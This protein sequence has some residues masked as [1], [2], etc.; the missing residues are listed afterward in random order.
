MEAFG[1]FLEKTE[2]DFSNLEDSLTL[3]TGS[4]GSGKTT[5]FDAICCALYGETSGNRRSFREMRSEMAESRETRVELE[6]ELRGEKYTVARGPTYDRKK[7][8]GEGETSVAGFAYLELPDGKYEE[9]S[10]AVTNRIVELLG[11]ELK[12]FRQIVMIAQNQFM[13]IIL[14]TNKVQEETFNRIFDADLF[15]KFSNKIREESKELEK[16]YNLKFAELRSVLEK[17]DEEIS[18]D[19]FKETLNGLDEEIKIKVKECKTYR[20]DYNV[21]KKALLE[22]QKRIEREKNLLEDFEDRSNKKKDLEEF[23]KSKEEIDE[24]KSVKEEAECARDMVRDKYNTLIKTR[25]EFSDVKEKL[26][27]KREEY[28]VVKQNRTDA[29]NKLDEY[30]EKE[31]QKLNLEAE[32]AE[33]KIKEYR[34]I[35]ERREERDNKERAYLESKRKVEKLDKAIADNEQIIETTEI[36]DKETFLNTYDP[37]TGEKPVR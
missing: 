7:K 19:D 12:E 5:I 8:R 13:G 16:A 11:I 36:T 15:V 24:K 20:A 4:T 31:L 29:K 37:L 25:N 10:K 3:I 9:K 17:E 21:K 26:K 34:N 14:G 2:I 6:F 23:L 27:A 18:E 22:I 33:E 1:P 28:K 32:T 30:S 35:E